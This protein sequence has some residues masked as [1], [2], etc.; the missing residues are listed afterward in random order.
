[1]S[2]HETKKKKEFRLASA[3]PSAKCSICG[4]K[5]FVIEE[6]FGGEEDYF[7]FRC[8]SQKCKSE[9]AYDYNAYLYNQYG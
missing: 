2:Q 1:M 9:F 3:Y 6:L 7:L 4:Y 5:S 8:L